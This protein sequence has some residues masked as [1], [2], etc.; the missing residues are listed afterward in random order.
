[1]PETGLSA[2]KGNRIRFSEKKEYSLVKMATTEAVGCKNMYKKS[3]LV[4]MVGYCTRYNNS[5]HTQLQC[6]RIYTY[7]QELLE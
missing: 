1:M 7:T 2:D 4:K 3:F 5:I 6:L